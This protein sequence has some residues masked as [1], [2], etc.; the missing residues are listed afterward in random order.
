MYDWEARL[1][2]ALNDAQEDWR[3]YY[4]TPEDAAIELVPDFPGLFENEEDYDD[5]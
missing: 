4:R 5:E 1:I 2:E 3:E